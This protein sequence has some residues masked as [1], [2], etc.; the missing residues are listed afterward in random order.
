MPEQYAW[1]L[2]GPMSGHP[3][4]NIPLFDRVA[5][6]MRGRHLN[7][8]SPAELDDSAIRAACLASENGAP[9]DHAMHGSWGDFLA[10][11][12][13][14]IADGIYGLILLPGWTRSRGARLE[15]FVAL[16]CDKHF[17]EYDAQTHVAYPISTDE[18]RTFLKG[19][20][21]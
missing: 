8:V 7:V 18:A 21:P 16:M 14:L 17:A 5:A 12:V 4:F 1:Y 15:V 11:D 13:K 6:E 9:L 20:M 3:R 10:R 19:N 2:C